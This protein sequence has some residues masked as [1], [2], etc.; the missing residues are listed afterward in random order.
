MPVTIRTE[1][2]PNPNA[3]RFVL[4]RPVQE[5]SRG[6]FFKTADEADEPLAKTLLGIEGTD[7]VMFLPNS[8]TVNKSASGAWE[9]LEKAV[10]QA[11]H[12]YFD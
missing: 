4:D 9:T 10:S 3:R 5:Q 2:T 1:E 7:S 8:V 12:E 6:R 11:L